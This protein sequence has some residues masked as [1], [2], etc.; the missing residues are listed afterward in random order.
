MATS[1]FAFDMTVIVPVYNA[2]YYL[3]RCVAS[4]DAQKVRKSSFEVIL[5]NDGSTD[6]SR[7]LCERM[8]ATHPNCTLFNQKNRGVS[9]ARNVGIRAARGRYIMF[10]DGDDTISPKSIEHL[11]A[12]FD[13]LGDKVDLLTYPLMYRD[14]LDGYEFSNTRYQWLKSTGVYDLAKY[15]FVAQT[16]VNVCVR[17]LGDANQLFDQRRS[18][19]EDQL[20]NTLVLSNKSAIGFCAR[21]QYTYY[22][23]P[24]SATML[25]DRPQTSFD[26]VM[27]VFQEYVRLAR[28]NEQFARYAYALLLYNVGWRM[29][30]RKLIP[31][32]GNKED[33][34]RNHQRLAEVLG[35]IPKQSWLESPYVSAGLHGFFAHE[36]GLAW[37]DEDT[38]AAAAGAI[39]W[40]TREGDKLFVKG[41]VQGLPESESATPILIVDVDGKSVSFPLA[42]SATDDWR[43]AVEL[44]VFTGD[45]KVVRFFVG[46]PTGEESNDPRILDLRFGLSRTNGR[47]ASA[48]VYRFAKTV[49]SLG[50]NALYVGTVRKIPLWATPVGMHL[51]YAKDRSLVP[52][53]SRRFERRLRKELKRRVGASGLERVWVY[54]DSLTNPK[55]GLAYH[56]YEQDSQAND[57][58]TRVYITEEMD[59]LDRLA[60][61]M[62]AE[63]AFS[64]CTDTTGAYPCGLRL[65]SCIADLDRPKTLTLVASSQASI[66]GTCYDDVRIGE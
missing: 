25:R 65:W 16:S 34:R 37:A 57:G 3:G 46:G 22:R 28:E 50:G 42:H 39:D 24:T 21:A 17:N 52:A 62:R 53:S 11:V 38:P 12:T 20:F 47:M 10:L 29:R 45:H 36:Y 26:D 1:R 63:R 13:R 60:A 64:S 49:V 35:E 19:S 9:S 61:F 27:S 32:F 40:L 56:A 44:P 18:N 14:A 59:L 30:E 7:E 23:V 33:R 58:V 6:G 5:I 55:R 51:A 15:P 43:F 2:R 54:M 31:N 66:E 48:R 41:Y 4:L 8:V